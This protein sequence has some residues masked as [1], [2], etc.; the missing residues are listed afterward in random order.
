MPC[1][2]LPVG[3]L[4]GPRIGVVEGVPGKK[5]EFKVRLFF[6]HSVPAFMGD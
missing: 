6:Q 3:G 2:P 1:P 5:R 4:L